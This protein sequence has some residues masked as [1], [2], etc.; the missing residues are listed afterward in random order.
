LKAGRTSALGAWCSAAWHWLRRHDVAWRV[1]AD[2][3]A[4]DGDIACETCALVIW[5]RS[6]DSV[7]HLPHQVRP[8]REP[9]VDHDREARIAAFRERMRPA[10]ERVRARMDQ[11]EK[12]HREHAPTCPSK[13]F[14][15]RSFIQ[16]EEGFICCTVCNYTERLRQTS[17]GVARHA[18]R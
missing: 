7:V 12:S 9:V 6:H 11:F 14:Q 16:G 18:Q 17:A 15:R 10:Y 1:N 3:P 2:P 13:P 8:V 4:C 5:C